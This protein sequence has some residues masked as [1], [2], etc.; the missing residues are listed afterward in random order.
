MLVR[1]VF[2]FQSVCV[3][4]TEVSLLYKLSLY[5]TAVAGQCNFL[6]LIWFSG[7]QTPRRRSQNSMP[8]GTLV[9]R[10]RA[11]LST[12]PS[13]SRLFVVSK[14]NKTKKTPS[15][16]LHC[17]VVDFRSFSCYLG[18]RTGKKRRL[19]HVASESTSFFFFYS[20]VFYATW[21][22]RIMECARL[23]RYALTFSFP[24]SNQG[25]WELSI[26]V[27]W[28]NLYMPISFIA[29]LHW[30]NVVHVSQAG[31]LLENA[32]ISEIFSLYFRKR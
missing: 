13:G 18:F 14:K 21:Q 1:R 12:F 27:L 30:G 28:Q 24:S 16:T 9:G 23:R 7:K 25:D 10:C 15:L 4:L 29:K 2:L 32:L 31:E 3:T 11:S 17:L 6:Y 8:G 26:S 5:K 22:K 19:Q 20:F